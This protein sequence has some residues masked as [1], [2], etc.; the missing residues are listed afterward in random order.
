MQVKFRVAQ[1]FDFTNYSYAVVFNTSGDG[2]T[3]IANPLQNAYAG[4]S[5][6]VMVSGSSPT[7]LGF[8]YYRP[9]QG[10]LPTLFNVNPQPQN[11]RFAV[12]NS[13]N[14]ELTIVFNRLE[15]ASPVVTTPTPSPTPTPT[16]TATPSPTPTPTASATPS[17]TPSPTPT[18]SFATTWNFNAFVMNGQQQ[19]NS[20]LTI[21]DSLGQGGGSDTTYTSPAIDTLSVYESGPI[22]PA[23]STN[24]PT[25]ASAQIASI[26]ITSTP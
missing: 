21:A 22:Y 11:L 16:P 26:D 14:T 2:K 1:A 12:T 17:P 24:H 7:A 8:T 25:N 9:G 19:T 15:M 5:F 6:V 13:T 10:A 20:P 18:P 3:P 4:Y 23:A